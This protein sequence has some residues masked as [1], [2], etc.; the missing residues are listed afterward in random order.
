MTI[1][2]CQLVS[3]DVYACPVHGEDLRRRRDERELRSKVAD[4]L[5]DYLSESKN[6]GTQVSVED[7][8]VYL[9]EVNA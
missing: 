8:G 5:A 1:C 6:E 3:H 7:F 9:V 2:T 4:L